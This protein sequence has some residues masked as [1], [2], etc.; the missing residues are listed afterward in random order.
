ILYFAFMLSIGWF[1][2]LYFV[3]TFSSIYV[4]LFPALYPRTILL[5]GYFDSVFS[6]IPIFWLYYFT[7]T[8]LCLVWFIIAANWHTNT[9]SP[10]LHIFQGCSSY[11]LTYYFYIYMCYHFSFTYLYSCMIHIEDNVSNKCGRGYFTEFKPPA[12]IPNLKIGIYV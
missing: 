6:V 11:P 2:Y 4:T 3:F 9:Q 1:P 12:Y 10:C 8:R 7:F 5:S